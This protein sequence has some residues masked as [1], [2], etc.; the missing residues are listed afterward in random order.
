LELYASSSLLIGNLILAHALGDEHAAHLIGT[1]LVGKHTGFATLKQM[2]GDGWK[3]ELDDLYIG[4]SYYF[5]LLFSARIEDAQVF[6]EKLTHRYSEIP[7]ARRFWQERLADALVLA[8]RIAEARHLYTSILQQCP[9][10]STTQQRLH[11]LNE[12]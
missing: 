6:A 5:A 9:A 12:E 10:C 4:Q 1:L 8:G 3:Q 7:A 2:F 11:A